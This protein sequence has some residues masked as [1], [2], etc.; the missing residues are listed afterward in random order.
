MIANPNI[1]LCPLLK[2]YVY[3]PQDGTFVGNNNYIPNYTEEFQECI[4][5]KC[6]AWNHLKKECKIMDKVAVSR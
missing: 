4:E 5:T 1:K 2:K 3:E 6:M